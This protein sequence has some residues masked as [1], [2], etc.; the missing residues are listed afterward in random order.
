MQIVIDFIQKF[1]FELVYLFAEMSPYLILGFALAGVLHVYF[2]KHKVAKY[3]G[4]KNL[5]SVVNAAILGIPLPLCSCGVIPTGISF[6]KNGASKGATVSFLISTPQTGVDS[7]LVTY[8]LLGLPFALIRP[9]AAFITGIFGGAL[10]NAMDDSKEELFEDEP[11]IALKGSKLQ[12]ALHYAFV[13]FLQDIAKWLV[14]GLAIAAFISVIIPDGFIEHNLSNPYLNMLIVLVASVPMYVCA[15]GSVPIAAVLM[16]KGLS[17]GAAFV[18]L[19]AGPATNAATMTVIKQ[20]MGTKALISY[21]TSIIGGALIMGV[22]V[23]FLPPQWFILP[24]MDVGGHNHEEMGLSW[25][26]IASAITLFL[27]ILNGFRLQYIP[28]KI[29]IE[30][31]ADN[32]KVYTVEGM[33]CNHCKA[34]VEKNLAKLDK[35]EFV[36]VDLANNAV[37]VKG[38]NID[39]SII[40]A[41]VKDLGYDYKGQK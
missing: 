2:P 14:V 32:E 29:K 41:A 39:N 37:K 4:R 18:F 38:E 31:M 17:P 24:G 28:T 34:S 27:L 11:E 21:L 13:E 36:E 30:D 26:A 6:N 35:I 8:S 19:M 16:M 22:L 40:E 12:T 33:T 10:T 3:L 1:F 23:D 7:M 25:F 15:T 5:K 9:I 20:S